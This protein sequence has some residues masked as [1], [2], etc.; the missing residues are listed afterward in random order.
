MIVS[1]DS[2][3]NALAQGEKLEFVLKNGATIHKSG[4]EDIPT[5]KDGLKMFTLLSPIPD[6]IFRPVCLPP[7]GYI[8]RMVKPGSCAKGGGKL[9]KVGKAMV[10]TF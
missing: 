3:Q 2:L 4:V 8:S 9:L 1:E 10:W 5:E 7:S 6:H